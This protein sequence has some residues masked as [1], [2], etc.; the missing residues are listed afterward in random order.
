[1]KRLPWSTVLSTDQNY[2]YEILAPPDLIFS[3]RNIDLSERN[4][5]TS[6]VL[7]IIVLFSNLGLF[8]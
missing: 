4:L 1:M 3:N 2:L 8:I 6:F 7:I 5:V